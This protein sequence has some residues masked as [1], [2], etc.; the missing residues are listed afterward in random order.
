[1][2]SLIARPCVL[3]VAGVHHAVLVH[4]VLPLAH[5]LDNLAGY[6]AA[7]VHVD[8]TWNL[9]HARGQHLVGCCAAARRAIGAVC[10]GVM[11]LVDLAALAA[12]VGVDGHQGV[13][14]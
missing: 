14:W 2:R 6:L 10:Y 9:H 5:R 12:T 11:L 13:V 7:I 4:D 3:Q 8:S 1:M